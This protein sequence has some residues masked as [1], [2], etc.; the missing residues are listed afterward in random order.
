M[1]ADCVSGVLPEQIRRVLM[2]S[3][4]SIREQDLKLLDHPCS[5]RLPLASVGTERSFRR[6]TQP[7]R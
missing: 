3:S 2:H 4:H 1:A 6:F 7:R 5:P